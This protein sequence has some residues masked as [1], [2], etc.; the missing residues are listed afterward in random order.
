MNDGWPWWSMEARYDW[1][2]RLYNRP[3]GR[4][5]DPWWWRP[6]SAV[7]LADVYVWCW[8]KGRHA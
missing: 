8:W 4:E 6:L 5:H 1:L 7:V 3:E 2:A